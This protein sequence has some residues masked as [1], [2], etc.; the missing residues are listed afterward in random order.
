MKPAAVKF[1]GNGQLFKCYSPGMPLKFADDGQHG[2]HGDVGSVGSEVV[3]K[4]KTYAEAHGCSFETGYRA[5]LE[6]PELCGRY[7]ARAFQFPSREGG[8][9]IVSG[10]RLEFNQALFHDRESVANWLQAH[11]RE[12]MAMGIDVGAMMRFDSIRLIDGVWV[13]PAPQVL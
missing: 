1:D 9:P 6:D 3:Q 13:Y 4:A 2:A 12:V 5:V 7:A 10:G 8:E 11:I